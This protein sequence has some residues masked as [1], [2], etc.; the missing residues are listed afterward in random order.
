[1]NEWVT[2]YIRH[3]PFIYII[4]IGNGI[5]ITFSKIKPSGVFKNP[6]FFCCFSRFFWKLLENVYF[7]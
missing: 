6:S 5:P 4:F 2:E 1:M 3:L 7:W